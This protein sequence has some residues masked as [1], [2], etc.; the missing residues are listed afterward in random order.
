MDYG[1]AWV[2]EDCYVAHHYGVTEYEGEF[3]AGESD[4]P[5]DREPLALLADY[6]LAD[7]TCS[8]HNG[9]DDDECSEC[10]HDG[11]EDGIDTF[12]MSACGGC[13]SGLGGSRYRLALFTPTTA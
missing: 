7:N 10:E 12:S 9:T 8:S 1:T 3:F 11:W 2:C 4:H 13:G 6:E 5:A